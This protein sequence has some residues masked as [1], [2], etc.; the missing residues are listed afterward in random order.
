MWKPNIMEGYFRVRSAWPSI[1]Y[2]TKKK[3]SVRKARVE[4]DKKRRE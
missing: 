4:K 2:V 3:R 1:I